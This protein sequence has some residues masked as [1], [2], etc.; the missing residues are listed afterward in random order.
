[1]RCYVL[2]G[3][4]WIDTVPHTSLVLP[5]I[6]SSNWQQLEKVSVC[7]IIVLLVLHP[8]NIIQAFISIHDN[9]VTAN[10][11]FMTVPW[12]CA[13]TVLPSPM[14]WARVRVMMRLQENITFLPGQGSQFSNLGCPA[15]HLH[16]SHSWIQRCGWGDTVLGW[17]GYFHQWEA[18][19]QQVNSKGSIWFPESRE[20]YHTNGEM[21][22]T[23]V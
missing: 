6:S 16:W 4:I 23:R 8:P 17:V 15:N 5:F 11:W 19:K 10:E 14:G 1:M 21:P 18:L 13:S 7:P 9:E 22:P 12:R 2:M 3:L 20:R